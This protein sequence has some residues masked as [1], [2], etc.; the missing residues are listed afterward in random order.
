MKRLPLSLKRP[1][2]GEAMLVKLSLMMLLSEFAISECKSS[3][4]SFIMQTI[5]FPPKDFVFLTSVS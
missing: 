5:L 3:H 4:Y 1:S 2:E